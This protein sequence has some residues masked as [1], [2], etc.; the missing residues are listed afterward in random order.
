M[1]LVVVWMP[2]RTGYA[3]SGLVCPCG[4]HAEVR[5]EIST[6]KQT[7]VPHPMLTLDVGASPVH[8]A[9]SKAL[10]TFGR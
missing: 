7:I 10:V 3:V 6:K 1:A 9:I 2:P 4:H 5:Q 8:S